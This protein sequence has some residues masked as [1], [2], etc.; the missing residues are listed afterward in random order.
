MLEQVCIMLRALHR[1]FGGCQRLEQVGARH[2]TDDAPALGVKHGDLA[3][4]C[5]SHHQ[6]QLVDG[7]SGQQVDVTS[8]HQ[9]A[10]GQFEFMAD[11]AVNCPARKQPHHF[12]IVHHRV[13]LVAVTLHQAGSLLK[14]G[15][16]AEEMRAAGHDL[17]HGYSGF[18]AALQL[19]H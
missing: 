13:A 3:P 2:D 10:G 14:R 4:A 1:L 17:F 19:V 11:G 5:G 7:V 6:L 15:R 18:D 9:A 8:F 12:P 16:G